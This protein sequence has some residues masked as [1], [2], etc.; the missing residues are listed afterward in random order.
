MCEPGERTKDLPVLEA[1][2]EEVQLARLSLF[3]IV[4]VK[5]PTQPITTWP[6]DA[7]DVFGKEGTKEDL[8]KEL[9][10]ATTVPGDYNHFEI[11]IP[12]ARAHLDEAIKRMEE[13]GVPE[14]M[15][16]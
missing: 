7:S 3:D 5:Y 10:G 12:H 16:L 6:T 14:F 9:F 1:V 15:G 13:A 11:N 8:F 4:N 2:H